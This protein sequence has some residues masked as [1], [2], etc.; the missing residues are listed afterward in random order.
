MDD[1]AREY[2]LI[3]LGVGELEEGLVDAYFGPP[4][5]VEE[6]RAAKQPADKLA[7]RA[8]AL[9][10][11]LGTVDDAQRARWLDR[12]LV[13][14]AALARNIGGERLPYVDEVERCFDARSERTPLSEYAEAR[15]A[16]A[17]LLP[18]TGDLRDR[19]VQREERLTVP[20]DRLSEA[21]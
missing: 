19:L 15:Q 1:V 20:A 7:A 4:E 10:D 21:I 14:L 9:R 6:A 18:G 17:D 16:L 8:D 13:A 2:L 3:G 12:Q 11:S 5:L